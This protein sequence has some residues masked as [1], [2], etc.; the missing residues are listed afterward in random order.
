MGCKL[1]PISARSPGYESRSWFN[2]RSIATRSRLQ[3]K[4]QTGSMCKRWNGA[5]RERAIVALRA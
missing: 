1:P 5:S 4:T 3:T 2:F